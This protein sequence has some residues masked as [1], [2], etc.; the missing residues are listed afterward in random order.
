MGHA[1]RARMDEMSEKSELPGR[2]FLKSALRLTSAMLA[3][4]TTT[5]GMWFVELLDNFGKA[6]AMENGTSDMN[7]ENF[8]KIVHD[9]GARLV[10]RR[11]KACLPGLG[12]VSCA[13][14]QKYRLLQRKPGWPILGA[15][16]S[17][18][19]F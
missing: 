18:R 2:E 14:H 7:V 1:V 17:C 5:Q 3:V 13:W 4:N 6:F 15:L 16:C 9:G 19:G 8:G 10:V 12:K 11:R